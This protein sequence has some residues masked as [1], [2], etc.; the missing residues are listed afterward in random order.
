MKLAYLSLLAFSTALAPA[1]A[2][3]IKLQS[4]IDA[5]T[6][7]PQGA[8]IV[9]V[10]AI[11][12][13]AGDHTLLLDDLPGGIDP[14]SIRVEG[15]GT[16]PLEIASVDSKYLQ[17]SS[18]DVDAKRKAIQDQIE[19]LS[20]ERIGLDQTIAD[21]E[22]QRKLLMS[23]ADKQ[24]QPGSSTETLKTVDAASLGGLVDLVGARMTAISK[25]VHEAQLRQRNIDKQIADLQVKQQTLAPDQAAHVQVA[26]HVAADAA[27]KGEIKV[28]YRTGGAGWQ[29]F[30]DAKLA[31]PAKGEKPKLEIVR[32]AQVMQNTG[33][34]W[35]NVA[36]T[37]STAQPSGST[38]APDLNEDPLQ[39]AMAESMRRELM[40]AAGA[41]AAPAMQ[42]RK[43]VLG[44][45]VELKNKLANDKAAAEAP[46]KQREATIQ[47][48]GFNANYLIQGRV[49]V[50]NTGAAKKVR[51]ATDQFDAALTA[52]T[53]PR[54]D[55]MAYLTAAFTLKGNA[56]YLPGVVNL[57]RDGMYVGQGLLPQLASGE[58][59][60]LGFGADDMIK[61]QRAE[62][63]RNSSTEGIITTSNVQELAWDITVKNLHDVMIPVTVIDRKPFST[64]SDVTVEDRRDMTPASV[65]DLDKKRGVLA[66]SFDLEPKALKTLKT[67]YKITAPE[68]VH[69][70][71][72]Q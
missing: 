22:A 54:L 47:L 46:A 60:K 52:V 32:R 42:A 55:P 29:P 64:Q 69:L 40:D 37:L 19:G 12:I 59:T 31:L 70:S 58:D 26:V 34:V 6:V 10:G 17:L 68:A 65:T 66:W 3:D 51:I 45:V 41:P 5:V 9:R 27:V 25:T 36:M 48:A 39:L 33:E 67:G 43:D 49:S 14:Q 2:D 18:E 21:A 28:S 44:K 1:F 4:H 24:L 61:V 53:V 57:F 30:Y 23:L 7:Y 72:N 71:M 13:K 16:S 11:D 38:A 35:D 8:D 62:V 63:K 15:S 50:D 20:D 56:P